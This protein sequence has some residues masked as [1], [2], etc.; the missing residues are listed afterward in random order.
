MKGKEYDLMKEI[1]GI[2]EVYEIISHPLFLSM[3]SFNH[4]GSVSCLEH[5]MRVTFCAY[6]LAHK[7]KTDLTS[8]LRGALLHDF[9]LYDWHTDSPGLHGFKHPYISLRNAQKHFSLNNKEVDAIK[10]HMWPL[11]PFPPRYKESI[12]V[13]MADKLVTWED[14]M[15][16]DEAVSYSEILHYQLSNPSSTL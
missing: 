6:Q 2:P 8:V 3:N 11:T 12:I 16:K 5:T 14:Y 1:K 4:H 7:R 13:S 10:R 9:Y 15:Q